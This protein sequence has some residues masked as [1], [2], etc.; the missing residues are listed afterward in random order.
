MST[1]LAIDAAS[2]EKL[3]ELVGLLVDKI[4]ATGDGTFAIEFVPAAGPFFAEQSSLL[5]APPTD[6]RIGGTPRTPW[7]GTQPSRSTDVAL[8][9]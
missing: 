4:V 6:A 7:V 3:K 1:A 5:M 8:T 9:G 2:A